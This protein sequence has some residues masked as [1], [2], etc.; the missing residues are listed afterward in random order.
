VLVDAYVNPIASIIIIIA[1]AGSMN[2][3]GA[4][5][6]CIEFIPI[7]IVDTHYTF[8]YLSIGLL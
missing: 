2:Q 7:I 5:F 4:L 6:R 8:V 1:S 3:H